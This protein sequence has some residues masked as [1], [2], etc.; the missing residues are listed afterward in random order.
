LYSKYQ[1][2]AVTCLG[3]GH[4]LLTKRKFD[5][6]VVDEATQIFQPTVIRPLLSAHRFILVGDPDQLSP[7]V[8]SNEARSLG[9]NESLFERLDNENAT[10][11]LGLQYRMN[12]TITKLANNLTY[13]GAL[14][15]ANDAI[16]KA[17]MEVPMLNL[18]KE[19]F[20]TD[21]WLAKVLSPHL[22]QAC[23]LINTG[24]VYEMSKM[25]MESLKNGSSSQELRDKS[26]LYINYCEIAI[27]AYIVDS[28]MECGVI[29]ES[30]GIIAPYRDQVEALKKI[31]Q[32]YAHVE[33]N[34]V[35][36]YQGRDK[37]IIIYSCTLTEATNDENKLASDDEILE[38]RRR[39][40]VAITRAK[41]KLIMVGDVN[42]LSKYTPFRDLFKHMNSMSKVQVQDEKM[43]FSWRKLMDGLQRK[44][45]H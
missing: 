43:G 16:E 24:N 35:D 36:Q 23:A 11:V 32:S 44:I 2:V 41:H 29:G 31:F 40:T 1:I 15:C 7:L 3:S 37:K 33:V 18:L 27:V 30:I 14:K 42:C 26:K 39:L 20:Q 34:T 10:F 4:S 12:K 21:K 45:L 8:R 38:D 19:K 17:C 28:L 5:Y 6:C 25:F 22:D 13:N 9:A